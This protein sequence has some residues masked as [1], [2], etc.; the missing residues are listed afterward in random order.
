MPKMKR[1]TR[2]TLLVVGEGAH[3]LAFLKHLK[4]IF[5]NTELEITIDASSGGSPYDVINTAVKFRNCAAF[6]RK[7]VLLDSDIALTVQAT[8]L[9][10]SHRVEVIQSSPVCL[11][12]MLLQVLAKTPPQTSP[13]CKAELHPL[14]NGHPTQMASYAVLFDRS[15]LNV[16]THSA[17]KRLRE[18]MAAN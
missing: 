5:G 17:I 16:C 7:A 15:V 8:K 4:T 18:L 1:I 2:K 14:L 10:K 12:G 6:D 3:E 13:L 11:E 9:A